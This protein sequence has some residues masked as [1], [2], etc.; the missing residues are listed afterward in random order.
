MAGFFYLAFFLMLFGVFFSMF[1]L[2]GG[3]AEFGYAL[4]NS[5]VILLVFVPLITM[6]VIGEERRSRTDQLLLTSGVKIRSIILGKFFALAFFLL[7]P[8][9]FVLLCPLILN[10]YGTISLLQAYSCIFVFILM[11]CA[12]ICVGIFFSSLTDKTILSASVTFALLLF[13]YLADRLNAL[14]PSSSGFVIVRLLK[15][16]LSLF[17]L[18][19]NY[20]DFTDG[21]FHIR[22]VVYYFAV[23]VIFLSAAIWVTEGRTAG[24][25]R[26]VENGFIFGCILLSMILI[27]KIVCLL[28]SQYTDFDISADRIY[29]VSDQTEKL[30]AELDEPVTI[31][32]VAAE[33]NEDERLLQLVDSYAAANRLITRSVVDPVKD[34]TFTVQYTQ[35]LL[36]EN[37]L[38][39]TAAEGFKVIHNK[40]IYTTSYDYNTGDE[41]NLFAGEGQI[42]S[43]IR[44]LT[45]D[46]L[47]KV[48]QL[49]GHGNTGLPDSFL[50]QAQKEGIVFDEWN[51][52]TGELVND[53]NAYVICS[54]QKDLLES[55][56]ELLSGYLSEGGT[57]LVLTGASSPDLPVL[58]SLLSE[59][60]Y[61]A[62][63]GV[64]IEADANY[65]IPSYANFLLPG[66]RSHEITDPLAERNDL[67]LFPNAHGIIPA[68]S[69]RKT[70]TCHDLLTTSINSYSKVDASSWNYEEGDAAGPFAVAV[71]AEETA[72]GIT[73]KIVWFS[74][75]DMLNDQIDEMVSGNN[76]DLVM[77]GL[78][79]MLGNNSGITVRPRSMKQASLQLTASQ[80]S[81][82]TNVFVWI[83]PALWILAGIFVGIIRKKG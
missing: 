51:A 43:A 66:M 5:S 61:A 8:V 44:Y 7:I 24:R 81:F 26:H 31:T 16:L 52:M 56:K 65:C 37:S 25:K 68:E 50:S 22:H 30:L 76:T 70:V 63:P 59:Y 13:A 11:G 15:K 1:N 72:G 35:D 48:Y 80:A 28:P 62:V 36:S 18:F 69:T 33:G 45:S 23:I 14:L 67:V 55:E 20:Y 47:Y 9:L 79:W 10:R 82:W 71:C 6:R 3:A 75:T 42:T 53:A 49:T 32:L 17:Y 78:Q 41:N 39:L 46:Y 73:S 2:R 19:R 4:G 64:I 77:N 29:T 34:P 57:L 12:C 74:S 83:I 58:H 38:I 40:D 27:Y 21:V 54:P 60:G